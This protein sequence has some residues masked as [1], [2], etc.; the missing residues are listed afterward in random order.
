MSEHPA[1]TRLRELGNHRLAEAL[2][3]FSEA[4]KQ[5]PPVM[6][7]EELK[8]MNAKFADP[9]VPLLRVEVGL[10]VDRRIC[11]QRRPREQGDCQ[12]GEPLETAGTEIRQN[13]FLH[14]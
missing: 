2:R 5:S 12:A 10:L 7:A 14:R 4:R 8:R 13:L 11:S 3:R 9:L 6:T 1:I